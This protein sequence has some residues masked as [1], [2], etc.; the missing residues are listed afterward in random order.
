METP[1]QTAFNAWRKRLKFSKTTAAAALG[2]SRRQIFSYDNGTEIVPRVVRL[3]ML[4]LEEHPQLAT[5]KFADG[6]VVPDDEV[7][8][9]PKV[10][11][12]YSAESNDRM[13]ALLKRL[14]TVVADEQ[15]KQA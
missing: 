12:K 3:A 9:D 6:S 14:R 15:K 4:A 10:A 2:R 11:A 5:L 8:I 1:R 7:I 13:A